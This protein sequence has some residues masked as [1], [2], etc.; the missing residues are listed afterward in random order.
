MLYAG[1]QLDYDLLIRLLY[2][3][4]TPSAGIGSILFAAVF[5]S[6]HI[7]W[8]FSGQVLTVCY[9][10]KIEFNRSEYVTFKLQVENRTLRLRNIPI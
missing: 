5:Y 6:L 9:L 4:C 2:L 3:I 10:S 7:T 1:T 8:Q